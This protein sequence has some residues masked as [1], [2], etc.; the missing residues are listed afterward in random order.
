M[1][2]KFETKVK[3]RDDIAL[4]LPMSSAKLPDLFKGKLL[5]LCAVG[6]KLQLEKEE[7]VAAVLM[8]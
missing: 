5:V 7:I 8:T 3:L 4:Q 6:P 2:I 1:P